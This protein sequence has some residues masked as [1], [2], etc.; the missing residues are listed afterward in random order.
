MTSRALN[1]AYTHSGVM[2]GRG[3]KLDKAK[4]LVSNL[5]GANTYAKD[6]RGVT[7][8]KQFTDSVAPGFLIERVTGFIAREQIEQF[9]P[10]MVSVEKPSLKVVRSE[11][12]NK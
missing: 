7:A 4:G 3:A 8:G 6:H 10:V 9:R 5:Q 11:K 12:V 2:Y 1:S